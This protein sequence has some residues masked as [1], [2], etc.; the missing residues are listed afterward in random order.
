MNTSTFLLQVSTFLAGLPTDPGVY[1]MLNEEGTVLYVG[2]AANL[3]KRVSS[4][5]NKQLES[6]KTKSL[7]AQIAAVDISV[8]RSETEAL[9]LE[10]SLIKSLRPKYNILMRDDKSYP[11]LYVSPHLFP[12]MEVKRS[13]QKPKTGD[14]YGPFPNSNAVRETLNIIQKV[15]K[16]RNCSDSY[17]SHRTR[18]CL[19][20]QIK[21]CSAPCTAYISMEDYQQSI[22]DAK[23]FLQGKSQAIIKEKLSLMEQAVA[24]LDF[25]EAARLRDQIQSLR[26]VQEQQGIVNREGE[27]DIIVLTARPGFACVQWVRVQEGDVVAC[28]HFFPTVPSDSFEINESIEHHLWQHV[29][30]A[31][32]MHFYGQ[33]PQRIPPLII[34]E[35]RLDE[36]ELLEDMLT[37]LRGKR[38]QIQ[39]QVRTKKLKWLDFARN[40]LQ[41]AMATHRHGSLLTKKRYQALEDFLN[42]P[43]AITRMECFDVSHTQGALTIA[44]CVVF[45]AEGPCKSAYRRFNITGITPGDDYAALRQ[46][47]YRRF[48]KSSPVPLPTVLIIDGGKGQVVVA[49]EV[50]ASLGI[51]SITLMGIAKG[52]TRKAG[53][54]QLIVSHT[55]KEC[56]LPSDSLALHLLQHIRDEAHRF[57]ITAH[58][59]K[60]Q[61]SGLASTLQS[62]PGIGRK[63]HRALMHYFGG[64]QGLAKASIEEMAKVEGISLALA[65]RVYEHF[66]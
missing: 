54:E 40:N 4:Y 53:W 12:R 56:V 25:E 32:V 10:S 49:E 61:Q 26:T 50:L 23:R 58:R 28:E 9:L 20:H 27:M 22:N 46:A 62:L 36:H 7:V 33:S 19:Q 14:Y 41:S 60:R 30:T 16:V 51:E 65:K 11:Y 18:P 45:D 29:F 39:Y 47:L 48:K 66:H 37:E 1:R 5:F 8:T 34:T 57:A 2:K 42:L 17:F 13:K 43:H 44:S 35:R 38:C 3:K 31:F 24:R 6:A 59:K 64:I 15:F 21:R 63:R 55:K 52:P